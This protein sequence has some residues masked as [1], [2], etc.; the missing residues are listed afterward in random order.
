MALFNAKADATTKEKFYPHGL[1]DPYAIQ[2]YDWLNAIEHGG[3]PETDGIV[4]LNDLAAAFAIIES[5]HAGRTV[6]L[7]EVLN[8][9]VA[10]YQQEINDHYG[11]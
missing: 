6:T 1:T 10:T 3:Q 5:S 11:I 4:G 2:Q 7:E 8:G 9:D